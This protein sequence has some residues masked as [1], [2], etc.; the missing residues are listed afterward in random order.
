MFRKP[1]YQILLAIF[2]L[3]LFVAIPVRAFAQT[4][5]AAT[6][7]PAPAVWVQDDEVTYVGKA[8]ERAREFLDWTINPTNASWTFESAQSS[9]VGDIVKFYRVIQTI[10]YVLVLLV[11]L[12]IAFLTI[13]SR[14]KK[15]NFRQL[16][17][18]IGGILLLITLTFPIIQFIY[19]VTDTVMKFF[20]ARPGHP[21]EYIST[22]DL[23]Y[24]AFDYN[25]QGYRVLGSSYDEAAQVSL[26]L[27]RAT[28][29]TYYVMAGVLLI[30]KIILW[31]FIIL[32]PIWVLLL[33]FPFI[34]NTAKIWMGEFFRWLF[35]APL[36]AILLAGLVQMWQANIPLNFETVSKIDTRDT[37][38]KP[39]YVKF[40][41]AISIL[42]G[43]PG[44]KIDLTNN[45]NTID[46]YAKYV[47]ALLMLWVVII[48]PWI[49]LRIFRDL[50]NAFFKEDNPM[51][52]KFGSLYPFMRPPPPN[53]PPANVPPPPSGEGLARD[54]G[55]AAGAGLAMELNRSIQNIKANNINISSNMTN[56]QSIPKANTTDIL[57]FAGIQTPKMTDI[58]RMDMQQNSLT[59]KSSILKNIAAPTTITNMRERSKYL[60]IQQELMS[61]AKKGDTTATTILKAAESARSGV[62]VVLA[63]VP[64]VGRMGAMGQT[65]RMGRPGGPAGLPGVRTPSGPAQQNVAIEDYEEVKKMWEENYQNGE[66]P[67]SE[68]IHSREEWINQELDKLQNIIELLSNADA[69]KK[70]QGMQEVAGLLP[71]LLLG[72]FS[73][74]ET[75]VYLKAKLEAGKKVLSEMEKKKTEEASK[76][77]VDVENKKDEA[78]AEGHLH[79]EIDPDEDKPKE[80]EEKNDPDGQT[81]DEANKD[82]QGNV[83]MALQKENPYAE[84]GENK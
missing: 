49:L 50:F 63:Q 76:E 5:P 82:M 55:K 40:P 30:R 83:D 73:E 45:V 46:T 67:I 8:A 77:T 80:G 32:S 24:I 25:F 84:K 10:S 39:D 12:F 33:P 7:T 62:P 78:H 64:S 14:G 37:L 17:L 34:R 9:G 41:T 81:P 53:P 52:E 79:A 59:N 44:E 51:M 66:V 13:V 60:T 56:L 2:A 31:F 70:K 35:Y 74:Q 18:V 54:F 65:G 22:Q 15:P 38:T 28:A 47:F 75:I 68:K 57:K 21:G 19:G 61:R 48:L 43:G 11:V 26:F 1:A 6:P 72:G 69:E 58:A 36:F 3:L 4:A 16:A 42:I 20:L 71:F 23:L 29:V 27:V